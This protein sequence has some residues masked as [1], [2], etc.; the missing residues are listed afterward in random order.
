MFNSVKL[1]Q[2]KTLKDKCSETKYQKAESHL[3]AWV[4]EIEKS[5]FETPN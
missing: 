5:N 1:F 4:T 3:K 2:E